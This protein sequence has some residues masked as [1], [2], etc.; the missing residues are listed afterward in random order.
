MKNENQIEITFEES[1]EIEI[2]PINGGTTP[3]PQKARWF[4]ERLLG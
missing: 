1:H 3:A 2:T 4:W